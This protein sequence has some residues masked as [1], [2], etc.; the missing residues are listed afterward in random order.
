M[1][2]AATADRTSGQSPRP[3]LPRRSRCPGGRCRRVRS[4]HSAMRHAVVV[5]AGHV[6][7]AGA[8]RMKPG[9][10]SPLSA[11]RVWLGLGAHRDRDRA[12]PDEAA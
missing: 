6:T 7:L 1:S 11:L 5:E 10:S 4:A 12:V 3:S 9:M 8:N 2:D